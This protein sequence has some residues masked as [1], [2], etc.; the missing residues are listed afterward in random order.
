[1]MP[2]DRSRPS[3]QFTAHADFWHPT[4][5]TIDVTARIERRQVVHGFSE[6]LEGC[7]TRPE[8]PAQSQC[9]SSGTQ[10]LEPSLTYEPTAGLRF[11]VGNPVS[12]RKNF[13]LACPAALRLH[14]EQPRAP[15]L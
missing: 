4:G 9:A 11:D 2:Y 10:R 14:W 13:D 3:L 12:L 15:G 6:V 8:T 5:Q 1:M 7:V